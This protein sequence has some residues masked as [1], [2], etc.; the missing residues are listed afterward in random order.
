VPE[1]AIGQ[2]TS[3]LEPI[4]PLKSHWFFNMPPNEGW[5]LKAGKYD[6]T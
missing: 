2:S 4:N 1:E 5:I 3:F 6:Y